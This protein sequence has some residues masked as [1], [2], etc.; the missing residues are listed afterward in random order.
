MQ[1]KNLILTIELHHPL[2]VVT[3][4]KYKL[5]RYLTTNIFSPNGRSH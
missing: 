5:M 4:P 2:D 1:L 3:I